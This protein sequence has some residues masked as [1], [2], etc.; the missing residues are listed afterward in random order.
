MQ[1]SDEAIM[2]S[3]IMGAAP[4]HM[5]VFVCGLWRDLYAKFYQR[6]IELYTL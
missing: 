4:V 1:A 3:K 2:Q 5:H 6:K